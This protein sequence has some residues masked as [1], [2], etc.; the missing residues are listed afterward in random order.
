MLV[1]SGRGF[2]AFLFLYLGFFTV[3]LLK[4]PLADSAALVEHSRLFD[5]MALLLAAG[6]VALYV[7]FSKRQTVREMVDQETGETVYLRPNDRFLFLPIRFW[8]PVY[9]VIG[10][11]LVVLNFVY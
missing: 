4:T 11:G 7:R 8:S 10:V 3:E 9:A 1:F 5:G 2:W 6:F